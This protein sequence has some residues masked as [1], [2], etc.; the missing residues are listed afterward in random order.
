MANTDAKMT[1]ADDLHNYNIDIMAIS[2]SRVKSDDCAK[3]TIYS[4]HNAKCAFFASC[5]DPVGHPA[6]TTPGNGGVGFILSQRAHAALIEWRPINSRICAAR[7]ETTI[8]V[9]RQHNN[10][11]QYA[12]V[13]RR[14]QRRAITVIAVYAPHNSHSSAAKEAFYNNTRAAI[15]ATPR[16][17]IIIVLGDT[18]AR[19]GALAANEKILGGNHALR[20]VARNDNGQRMIDLCRDNHLWL[21]SSAFQ[22]CRRH[23]ATFR[24]ANAITWKQLDH[25]M[26]SRRWHQSITDVRSHWGTSRTSDHALVVTTLNIN[27]RGRRREEAGSRPIDTN[28]LNN[29]EEVRADF[30][31]LAAAKLNAVTRS[32]NVDIQA[33][34]IADIVQSAATEACGPRRRTTAANNV[35][36]QGT[37]TLLQERRNRPRTERRELTKAIRQSVK[38]DFNRYYEEHAATA[39]R[40]ADAGDRRTLFQVIQRLTGN[41]R[42][43]VNDVLRDENGALTADNEGKRRLLRNHF[44]QQFNAPPASQPASTVTQANCNTQIN[45]Q[46]PSHEEVATVLRRIKPRKAS[47]PDGVPPEALRYAPP[48]VVDALVELLAGVWR[49]ER[50][51]TEWSASTCVPVFKKGNRADCKNYRGINLLCTAAKVLES[52]I[53]D[54]LQLWREAVG[55]E[56]QTGFRRGRGCTDN[57]FVIRQVLETRAEFHEPSMAAFLDL[58]GAFDSVDRERMFNAITEL[59]VPQNIVNIIRDM[60]ARQQ[61]TVRAFGGHSDPF[62]P[63]TGVWQGGVLSPALF[64]LVMDMVMNE[65]DRTTPGGF[66][67]PSR[68]TSGGTDIFNELEYAD[69]VVLFDDDTAR[70]QQRLNTLS[71]AAARFGLR[72]APAKCTVLALDAPLATNFSIDGEP[73]SVVDSVKYL[74]S[75]LVVGHNKSGDHLDSSADIHHRLGAATSVFARMANIWRSNNI[76][77]GIK[78]QLYE[79]CVRSVLLYGAEQWTIRAVDLS[80]LAAF[81]NGC[82]RKIARVRWSDFLKTEEVKRRV[83]GRRAAKVGCIKEVIDER[84]LRWLGHVARQADTRLP[85]RSLA[86]CAHP[87][88]R[89]PQ[90]GAPTVW[91]RQ[92]HA[93]TKK[94]WQNARGR[95]TITGKVD[96]ARSDYYPWVAHIRTIAANRA[97][98]R[99]K[100]AELNRGAEISDDGG[101]SVAP[102]TALNGHSMRVLRPRSKR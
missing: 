55:R 7:F 24:P 45:D 90:G 51:P 80:S 93:K 2:E 95:T 58:R 72:F 15:R 60:Y 34:T 78:G 97:T 82:I 32:D 52:I 18:N 67:M 65:L 73:I 86:T 63:S 3:S 33:H 12:R 64:T 61:T 77:T 68:L 83:F 100:C 88:W 96:T 42:G 94:L 16:D 30:A 6:A 41:K 79:A 27:V 17:D 1:V 26:V 37:R 56:Q 48:E 10:H 47:G 14:G 49:S 50:V 74:G 101:D 66:T 36:S 20:S 53:A 11:Q 54:R 4:S 99:R 13:G 69:D 21:A 91:R 40:A 102:T 39:M 87:T 71:V 76:A 98:W 23:T 92:M 8:H 19:V 57:L 43:T 59:G 9:R 75:R 22:H 84:V 85:I 5:S 89:R 28:R 38:A 29:D 31:Q 35:I 25:V 81:D 46:P 62:V 44:N 70:M